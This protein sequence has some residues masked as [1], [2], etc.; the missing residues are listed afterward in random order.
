[1]AGQAMPTILSEVQ[2]DNFWISPRC[3]HCT[4]HDV[5]LLFLFLQ[6]SEE[7]LDN[8]TE[9][10]DLAMKYANVVPKA[11]LGTWELFKVTHRRDIDSLA[12]LLESQE[13]S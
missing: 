8:G 1:M 5:L 13:S 12:E 10:L 3:W 11:I 2:V 4:I 9:C 7:D 6:C